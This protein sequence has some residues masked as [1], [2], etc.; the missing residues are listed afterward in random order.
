MCVTLYVNYAICLTVL[1]ITK[2]FIYR[3]KRNRFTNT[4]NKRAVTSGERGKGVGK[5]GEGDQETQITMYMID[6]LQG[7]IAQ[8]GK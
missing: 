2:F 1:T 5:I 7:Y 8:A 6:K 4:E 3:Q